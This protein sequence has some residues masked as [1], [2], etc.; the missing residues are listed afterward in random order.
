MLTLRAEDANAAGRRDVWLSAEGLRCALLWGVGASGAIV[1]IE[2]SPYEIMTLLSIAV[3][4]ITGVSMSPVFMPVLILMILINIGYCI[5]AAPIIDEPG[6]AI[7]L[8]TS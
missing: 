4:A 2:P 7:W 3:F 8:V 1:F 5:A 6:I